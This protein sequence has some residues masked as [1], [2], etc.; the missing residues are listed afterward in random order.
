[1]LRA[2]GYS[3]VVSISQQFSEMALAREAS[4]SEHV[5]VFRIP[6][7]LRSA[8]ILIWSLPMAGMA[9]FLFHIVKPQG[10]LIGQIAWYLTVGLLGLIGVLGVF[11]V[12][13][14]IPLLWRHSSVVVN[15]FTRTI[16][17]I[18]QTPLH[19]AQI[20]SDFDTIESVTVDPV[21]NV[22]AFSVRV[23]L[24][25][26]LVLQLGRGSGVAALSLAQ[27]IGSLTNAPTLI[28][29]SSKGSVVP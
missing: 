18:S 9:G 26:G 20:T 7:R 8:M 2:N 29:P 11:Y 27:R 24:K 14:T 25:T 12:A 23:I 19:R 1:M 22:G 15:T 6:A 28:D 16:A 4:E 13:A 3:G 5:S 21:D 10:G 17:V